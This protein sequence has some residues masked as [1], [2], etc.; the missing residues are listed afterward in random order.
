MWFD[1]SR[2]L[3]VTGTVLVCLGASLVGAPPARAQ[4]VPTCFGE[5]AT[6]VGE[7]GQRV[8]HGSASDD[9]IVGGP[10]TK[11]YGHQG[12]DRICNFVRPMDDDS[13]RF[14]EM[15]GGAG[16]DR[17]LGWS[18]EPALHFMYGGRGGDR[19]IGGA[20]MHGGRGHDDL[21]STGENE[22]VN[23][24]GGRGDDVMVG[25]PT[26]DQFT[27]GPGRDTIIG[28]EEPRCPDSFCDFVFVRDSHVVDLERG[29]L[30]TGTERTSLINIHMV[31]AQVFDHPVK[32]LGSSEADVLTAYCRVSA[33]VPVCS[34]GPATID[35]RGGDDVIIG[36]S[37][38]DL[39]R[40][41]RGDDLLKGDRRD[42][43]LMGGRGN[44]RHNGG[45]G[46]DTCTDDVG[47]N[48]VV[49]CE[50]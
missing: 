45:V 1:S 21:T 14:P 30:R 29:F 41:R 23:L 43:T 11:I 22:G 39:L 12:D 44:D 50:A 27:A 32:L 26:Q 16:H 7:D 28:S 17:L 31:W 8:I 38:A 33:Q 35:G 48:T 5:P 19:L 9:V 3:P 42:D 47:V 15:Y 34:R 4:S 40:G 10:A 25:G 18:N 36:G 6:I 13:T 46:S 20:P 2:A 37:G 49:K 24:T